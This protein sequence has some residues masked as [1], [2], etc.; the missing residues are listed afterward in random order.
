MSIFG[1]LR[2]RPVGKALVLTVSSNTTSPTVEAFLCPQ[3]FAL[4]VVQ[5]D[6][7]EIELRVPLPERYQPGEDAAFC[8]CYDHASQHLRAIGPNVVGD[9]VTDCDLGYLDSRSLFGYR[10]A[11][12]LEP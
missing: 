9:I 8:L 5:A 12:G 3:S 11:P 1:C 2:D 10:V 7:D 6:A 4:R